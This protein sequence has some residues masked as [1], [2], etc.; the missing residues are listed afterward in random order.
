MNNIHQVSAALLLAEIATQ[1]QTR[2]SQEIQNYRW[3]FVGESERVIPDGTPVSEWSL[4][5]Q[6]RVY[7][8]RLVETTRSS[9]V[10]L[11]LMIASLDSDFLQD[12]L[13]FHHTY[14]SKY[15]ADLKGVTIHYHIP[16]LTEL[17]L[18]SQALS[19]NTPDTTYYIPKYG[20]ARRV[21]V[22]DMGRYRNAIPPKVNALLGLYR[23]RHEDFLILLR[24][25]ANAPTPELAY[26]RTP[27]PLRPI[28][29]PD[30]AMTADGEPMPVSLNQLAVPIAMRHKLEPIGVA[31]SPHLRHY[32]APRVDDYAHA[33]IFEDKL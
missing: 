22:V 27:T 23:D 19:P 10:V 25:L 29:Y 2:L 11:D 17:V 33:I 4:D 18:A 13:S 32:L 3:D 28:L 30:I 20:S 12:D 24:V 7:T 9:V 8:E 21:D 14:P 5:K 16:T 6:R 1:F 15:M 31:A 26:R